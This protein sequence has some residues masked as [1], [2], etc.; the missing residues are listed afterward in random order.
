MIRR[1]IVCLCLLAGLFVLV[2]GRSVTAAPTPVPDM[3]PD[4]SA[5]NYFLGTWKCVG[6]VRGKSRPDTITFS[7]SM[8][9]RWITS[10]DVAPPF[11]QYRTRAIHTD[12]WTTYNPLN[13][14]WVA[15]YIDD[16]G[17]YGMSTSPGWNGT[18]LT[19]TVTVAND[20][21]TGH[22]TLTKVS[23]T[24]TRDVAWSTSK[25]GKPNP[26]VTTTCNKQ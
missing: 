23:D 3:K 26:P 2:G 21:T 11:D 15:T 20:G 10:H 4:L 16:F 13:H 5:M 14:L 1:A 7:T 22:D 24:R 25:N 8:D 6:M 9:G 12:A 17:G 19:T 18:S